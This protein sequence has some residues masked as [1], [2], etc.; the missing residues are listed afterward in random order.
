MPK[1]FQS[2]FESEQMFHKESL[3]IRTFSYENKT[4]KRLVEINFNI[5]LKF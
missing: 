3:L 5:F 4:E 1:N 2:Y